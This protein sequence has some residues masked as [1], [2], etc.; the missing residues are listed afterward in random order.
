MFAKA[1][2]GVLPSVR[3]DADL[4]R[5]SMNLFQSCR[6]QALRKGFKM[7]GGVADNF[8]ATQALITCHVWAVHRR[9]IK[10]G[11]AGKALDRAVFERFWEDA[12]SR[13][14]FTDV[15]ELT[16]DRHLGNVQNLSFENMCLFDHC[17][18]FEDESE[19]IEKLCG[20]IWRAVYDMD[21]AVQEDTAV[22]LARYLKTE[23]ETLDD[24]SFEALKEGR[25][26]WRRPPLFKGDGDAASCDATTIG[27][28][29]Y[30]ESSDDLEAFESPWRIEWTL[31]GDTYFWH[32]DTFETTW[33]VD[34]GI[35][36]KGTAGDGSVDE[37][38]ELI[39]KLQAGAA[40]AAA[41]TA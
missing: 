19:Q 30:T 27:N 15:P 35:I 39:Q 17:L 11:D 28:L 4:I 31:R 1:V 7:R 20:G 32:E 6:T 13:I 12:R 2:L 22:E 36:W 40:E 5:Q 24:V 23:A 9:L 18:T 3:R 33:D 29:D 14:R 8:K 37:Q 26:E 10:E 21:E 41:G 38:G 34:E 16:V 25:V